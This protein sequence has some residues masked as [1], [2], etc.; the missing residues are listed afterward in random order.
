MGTKCDAAAGEEELVAILDAARPKSRPFSAVTSFPADVGVEDVPVGIRVPLLVLVDDG[1]GKLREVIR[2][3][4]CERVEPALRFRS[5]ADSRR[6]VGG[7]GRG[8]GRVGRVG[9]E[10]GRIVS[11]SSVSIFGSVRHSVVVRLGIAISLVAAVDRVAVLA[12]ERV[13]I[14]HVPTTTRLWD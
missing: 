13:T 4:L 14:E 1:R 11:Q 6:G 5:E 9:L 7:E 10:R 8:E 12:I 2:G 3:A